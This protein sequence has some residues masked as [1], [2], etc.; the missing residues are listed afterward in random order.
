MWQECLA[1][2][3]S[4]V[5]V[6]WTTQIVLY[7]LLRNEQWQ[8]VMAID[9]SSR[10]HA[11]IPFEPRRTPRSLVGPGHGGATVLQLPAHT[12]A[13]GWGRSQ[14]ACESPGRE[15]G[16]HFRYGLID[17]F[18]AAM[19]TNMRIVQAIFGLGSSATWMELQQRA[20]QD[21][22]AAATAVHLSL[23]RAV[24]NAVAGSAA[25][26]RPS[27]KAPAPLLPQRAVE[28]GIA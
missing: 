6:I 2:E 14:Q 22:V 27:E 11:V 16:D 12:G 5:G 28:G 19:H 9:L 13:D 20:I 26:C 8:A 24:S 10:D 23:V 17:L 4:W 3:F 1:R 18:E 7:F 25:G 21:S 15:S